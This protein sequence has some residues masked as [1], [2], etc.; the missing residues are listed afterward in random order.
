[1]TQSEKKVLPM[2]REREGGTEREVE[3]KR[4]PSALQSKLANAELSDLSAETNLTE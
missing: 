2:E 3:S 1:M 4:A